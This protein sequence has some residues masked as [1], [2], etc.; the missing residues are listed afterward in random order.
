MLKLSD[1]IKHN[2]KYIMENYF[3]T[4]EYRSK[5]DTILFYIEHYTD[6]W[7]FSPYI[8]IDIDKKGIENLLQ[9]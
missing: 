9:F 5:E 8:N 7:V 2:K 1:I 3:K 4:P 6:N